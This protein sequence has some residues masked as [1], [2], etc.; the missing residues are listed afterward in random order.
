LAVWPALLKEKT[1]GRQGNKELGDPLKKYQ[2]A[3]SRGKISIAGGKERN[4][5]L[6][7]KE[8]RRQEGE[9]GEEI[10]EKAFVQHPRKTVCLIVGGQSEKT[11]DRQGR[12]GIKLW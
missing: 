1:K 8:S 2:S 5:V 4:G 10:I 12:N 6:L 7:G 9:R 3:P 11:Q